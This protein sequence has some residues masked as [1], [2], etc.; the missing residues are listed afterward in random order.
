MAHDPADRLRSY[1]LIAAE[2]G[3]ALPASARAK[4]LTA[5]SVTW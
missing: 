1:E 5:E 3:Q 2:I 4:I